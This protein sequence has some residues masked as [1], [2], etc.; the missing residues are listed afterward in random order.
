MGLDFF[1]RLVAF[2]REHEVMLVHDFAYADI[3]FDGYRPPSLLEVPGAKDV[4]VELYTLSKSHAMA[5]WRVGFAVGNRDMIGALAK[6]KSYLDYGTFQPIQIAAI[7]ALNE[8]DDYVSEV[9]DIY[10]RRRDTLVDGLNRIGWKVPRPQGTMFVWGRTSGSL[11]RCGIA[12]ILQT[13]PEGGQGCC[14]PR[15]RVR[16]LGRW[17][18]Q[19][20]SGGK[21][22]PD[23]P[24][25][26]R[27]TQGVGQ[28]VMPCLLPGDIASPPPAGGAP[29]PPRAVLV[30]WR[31]RVASSRRRGL[32]PAAGRL[33][34]FSWRHRVA[35]SRRRG[36]LPR[37]GPCS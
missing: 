35:S 14:Q 24:G 37:R 7:I 34:L 25:G 22:A 23:R 28:D 5:G 29:S 31:H 32:Y 6:L 1:E 19:V 13:A 36:P 30:S 2:A 27:D 8:G 10:L 11:R 18:C 20:R 16:S 26:A 17:P 9:S 3:H 15:D 12:R 4:G 33:C 21:R